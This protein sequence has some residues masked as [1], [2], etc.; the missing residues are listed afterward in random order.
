MRG[1]AGAEAAEQPTFAVRLRALRE[2]AS[3]SQEELARRAH[4]TTHAISALER[5]TRTRPYP[6]TIRAIADALDASD[7]DRAALVAAVPSRRRDTTRPTDAATTQS[8]GLPRPA[9]PLVARE[10]EV[11]AVAALLRDPQQRIVTLTGPGGVGK[12]RLTIAA[13]EAAAAAFPDGVVFVELAPLVDPTLVLP[14]IAD[15]VAT[16]PADPGD[17]RAVV[18]ES[19]GTSTVLLV[20]DNVEHLLP[21]ASDVARLVEA[22]PGLTVLA[23]SRAALRVRGETEFAVPPLPLPPADADARAVGESPAGALFLDRARRLVPDLDLTPDDAAAVAEICTRLAGIPL[24]LELAAAHVRLLEPRTLLARLDDVV[25]GDGARDL[26]ARQRTMRAALDW[27]HGLLSEPERT[28]LRLL[29]VFSGGFTLEDVEAVAERSGLLPRSRVLPALGALVEQSLVVSTTDHGVRRHRML[30]PVAQYAGALLAAAGESDLAGTAHTGHFLALAEEAAPHYERAQQIEWLARIDGAHANLAAALER[31]VAAGDGE[32]AGRL[33]WSLWLYWWLR[34]HVRHGRRQMESVLRH[35]MS[36]EVR[37][38]AELSLATMA[39]AGDDVVA[40]RTSWERARASAERSGDTS[41]LAKAVS[42]IGL[43]ALSTGDVARAREQFEAALPLAVASGA[44]GEWVGTLT[45][46]WLGTVALLEGDPDSAV[47]HIETGLV[48]ARHRRDRL[49]T[50]I[51][52]YNLSQVA[53]SR[54]ES[55]VARRHLEE[56]LR[57]SMETRD[58][59]NLAHFLEVLAVVEGSERAHDRVPVLLGAAQG[60]REMIGTVGYGYYRPDQELAQRAEGEARERLGDDTFD[61][62]LD[63]GRTL[64]A[65]QAVAF[66]LGGPLPC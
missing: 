46:V 17:A 23:S 44:D 37:A 25:A 12:T 31:A 66:A 2:A 55:T 64:E 65:G 19:I 36:D 28:L 6:H 11:A 5:G 62:A 52:L 30:E 13:T 3:L 29:S 9:T 45:H 63:A 16:G 47:G 57:L 14:T 33:G 27:S 39:F 21:A 49:S 15:C 4:L 61:D 48:S 42:G 54:G 35:E 60:I 20:L 1:G 32:T 34:G 51:A 41:A 58:L 24:A 50:Y 59:A 7:A 53:A 38:R 40:A 56:G 18:V 8:R 26:P 10:A 43:A 22:C